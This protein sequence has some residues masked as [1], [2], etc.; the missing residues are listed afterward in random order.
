MKLLSASVVLLLLCG[1]VSA[2]DLGRSHLRARDLQSSTTAGFVIPHTN[3]TSV[4]SVLSGKS[5]HHQTTNPLSPCCGGGKSGVK[6]LTFNFTSQDCSSSN[7]P[8]EGKFKCT[9]EIPSGDGPITIKL[10]ESA[11]FQDGSKMKNFALGSLF[12]IVPGNDDEFKNGIK[13][14]IGEYP[15]MFQLLE[16]IDTSCSKRLTIGNVFGGLTLTDYFNEGAMNNEVCNRETVS[17]QST[18]PSEFLCQNNNLGGLKDQGCTDERKLCAGGTTNEQVLEPNMFGTACKVCLNDQSGTFQDSGC[19]S[20]APL[21]DAEPDKFGELC[22]V[23]KD[24][25][26]IETEI[27]EGCTS[28][29]PY[30]NGGGD[31]GQGTGCFKC[32][33]TETQGG[34]DLGCISQYPICIPLPGG[35]GNECA[36]CINDEGNL[37]GE[38]DTGCTSK[39]PV[40]VGHYWNGGKYC[41]RCVND[42]P[43]P[44]FQDSGCPIETPVCDSNLGKPGLECLAT[45]PTDP[46][47]CSIGVSSISFCFLS[48]TLLLPCFCGKL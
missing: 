31:A 38:I 17:R 9:G 36:D 5:S 37:D 47:V 39:F 16:R 14:R 28:E 18:I 21:C 11:S 29:Q 23:C 32:Q 10:F 8:Q 1:S 25:T 44:S 33:D 26:N 3:T 12:T 19:P 43:D 15:D 30:C 22:F 42:D 13:I 34:R 24:T 6:S 4:D 48:E 41:A 27:D 45:F 40:C 7:N 2:V 20:E 35:F 46:D